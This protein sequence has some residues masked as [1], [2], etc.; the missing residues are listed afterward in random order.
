MT[1]TA[2]AKPTTAPDAGEVALMIIAGERLPSSSGAT[3]EVKNPATGKVVAT[4]ARGTP[5]DVNK[6]VAAAKAVE[7]QWAETPAEDRAALLF[8]GIELLEQNKKEIAKLLSQEQG[9]PVFEANGEVHHMIHGLTFYAGLASK[10]RG[11]QVPVPPAMGK[12]SYGMIVRRPVGISVGITPWNLP[13]TLMGT[14]VG[15]ALIAGCPIIIKPAQ[16]TPLSTLRVIELL[17]QAGIPAGVLQCVTGFGSELGDPATV[18][19]KPRVRMGP[20]HAEFQRAEIEDQL[21]DAVAKG[22][23]VVLGGKRP[24]GLDEGFY[25]EPTIVE[26]VSD[27]SKLVTEEVFGPVLP[28]FKY[29]DLDEAIARVNASEWGLGSSIWTNN[30]IWANRAVRDIEAGV[31][32]VNMIHYGYDELPFGG[33][34][35]SGIGREHGPEAVDFY[36]EDKGV[37]FGGLEG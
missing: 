2:D 25:F 33:V 37:V 17:N 27:D 19:E 32:W 21:A 24:E 4:V 18:P 7:K 12:H 28:V 30:M 29:K 14:K 23:K 31:T 6:A 15:P 26:N 8:K 36:L 34:K 13:L 35:A 22:A 16:T 5:D 11:S 3:Y 20:L 10:I 9:K 1:Q